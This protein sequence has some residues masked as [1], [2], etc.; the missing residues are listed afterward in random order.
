M[1]KQPAFCT[2]NVLFGSEKSAVSTIACIA[3]ATLLLFSTAMTTSVWAEESCGEL[4]S[5]RCSSCHYLTRICQKIEKNQKKGFFGNVFAG[6]WGRTIKNM[7]KQGAKLNKAELK[8]LT[9]CLDSSS[10]E[11]LKLCDLKK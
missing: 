6:S 9:L 4:L 3:V 11:V 5:S 10:P 7:V 8:K 2:E 1:K